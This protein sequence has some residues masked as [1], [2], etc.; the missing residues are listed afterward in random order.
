MV[1]YGDNDTVSLAREAHPDSSRS[2]DIPL[3]LVARDHSLI[4]ASTLNLH[5]LQRLELFML[6]GCHGQNLHTTGQFCQAAYPGVAITGSLGQ[7][8]NLLL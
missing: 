7:R 5:F 6:L 1:G 4:H 2:D 8:P 3:S